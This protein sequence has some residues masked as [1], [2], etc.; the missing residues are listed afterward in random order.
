MNSVPFGVCHCHE[1]E[2]CGESSQRPCCQESENDTR[3]TA[4][5]CRPQNGHQ[6]QNVHTRIAP[7]FPTRIGKASETGCH[8]G[9][10]CGCGSDLQQFAANLTVEE[11]RTEG[12]EC[13]T[14][15]VNTIASMQPRSCSSVAKIRPGPN[16]L[17]HAGTPSI[18]ILHSRLNL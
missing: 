9:L 1:G 3:T 6:V 10:F 4:C 13:S 16:H 5:C 15:I 11:F 17:A 7:A 18:C 8:C 14:P 2:C 12:I